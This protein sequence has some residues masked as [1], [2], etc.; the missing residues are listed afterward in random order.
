M[1]QLA[2]RFLLAAKSVLIPLKVEVHVLTSDD[3]VEEEDNKANPRVRASK[4]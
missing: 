3:D 4:I 1:E 2:I